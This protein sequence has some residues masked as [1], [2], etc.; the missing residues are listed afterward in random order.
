MSS[1]VDHL[2]PYPPKDVSA[3]LVERA[4]RLVPVL[5]ERE[6]AADAARQVP[7]ETIQDF[8]D[9]G[10]FRILQP[11]RHGGY[12]LPLSVYCDVAR[13][14]AE[15]CM[16]S[17]WVYGVIAVHNWQLALFD[18][19]AAQDVWGENSDVRI[20]SSYMPVGKVTPVE[21]GYRLSGRWAF[22]SG[23]AHCDWV[24]LGAVVPGAGPDAPREPR[25]FL[26]PRSDY[27]LVD[28]WDVMGLRATGSNDVVVDDAFVPDYRT[29]RE[30]DMF[31]LECPGH[32][33]N[34]GSLYRMPFAQ[35]FNRTVST[36]SLGALRRAATTFVGAMRE[37][38]ATY[39]GERL[40][41]DTTI[42]HVVAEVERTLDEM[43]LVLDRDV[44]ELGAR[45]ASGEWP[46]LRRAE[47]GF[48]TTAT[49]SRCVAE[50]DKL[51]TFSGGKAIYRGNP[52]QRAFLDIH[53]ARAH[54][55]NNPYP[56]GRNLGA[57]YFGF[58]ADCADI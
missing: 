20:S 15:G 49:V 47:L 6:A 27:A 17:A 34:R 50:I 28:V 45:A 18:D 23:S 39:T 54:V 46:M 24:I 43:T 53:C 52:I 36:T 57:M 3:T 21:G 29:I 4:R 13:T 30:D 48:S 9:A 58:D 42:Q 51:M 31:A 1:V 44:A 26:V 56:Y 5:Q 41:R 33:V 32:A 16:S 12:E 40:A 10:F 37:K 25:N 38:R 8:A 11:K 7:V 19:R 14:L 35:I 55:A 22:S 2:K